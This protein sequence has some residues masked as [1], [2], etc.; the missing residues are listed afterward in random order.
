MSEKQRSALVK[1]T[2]EGDTLTGFFT[3]LRD[4]K[5]SFGEK[6]MAGFRV[7]DSNCEITLDKKPVDVAEG[8][9]V[10]CFPTSS[11]T[12]QLAKVAEGDKVTVTL[13]ALL[14]SKMGHPFKKFEV[15]THGDN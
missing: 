14:K 12:E 11:L 10:T 4:V 3:G 15:K 13:V 7:L 1:F 2:K 5:T 6:V 8:D 9:E